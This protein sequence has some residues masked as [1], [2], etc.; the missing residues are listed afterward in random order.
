MLFRFPTWS[1]PRA[2]LSREREAPMKKRTASKRQRHNG[3]ARRNSQGRLI[4][5]RP[6]WYSTLTALQKSAYDRTTNLITALRRGEGSYTELLRKHHLDSRTA[7]EYAG[8][9]LLGGTRGK[10]VRASKADRR[11]RDLLFPTS[12]G[13]VRF[14]TRSSRDAT[15]LADYYNDRDKLLRGKLGV[16]DFEAKWRGVH[17]A[18]REVFADAAQILRMAEA[19]SLKVEDLYASVGSAE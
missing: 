19:D 8:R 4:M 11:V 5:P 3:H 1:P 2:K 7:R 15:K 9:D 17:I 12:S 6:L 16:A 18:G 13:D 10:P 14:R